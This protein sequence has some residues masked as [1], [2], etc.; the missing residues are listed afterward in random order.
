MRQFHHFGI[1]TETVQEN[2]TY[3]EEAKLSLPT[4]RVQ[5]D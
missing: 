3:L 4:W 2:E 1:P 5:F